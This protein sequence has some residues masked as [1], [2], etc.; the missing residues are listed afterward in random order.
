MTT[1]PRGKYKYDHSHPTD[2]RFLNERMAFRFWS[3]VRPVDSGCW[4]WQGFRTPRLGYGMFGFRNAMLVAHRVAYANCVGEIPRGI[5]VCHHC[6]NPRCVNPT[7]LFLGTNAD[8]MADM[9]R[10]GRRLRSHCKRGH[11]LVEGNV[12]LKK[13]RI[14]VF[15][16]CLICIRARDRE[17]S[18]R[19]RVK[20]DRPE[21]RAVPVAR[22]LPPQPRMES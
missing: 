20:C 17:Y 8:N 18:R 2:L 10:K 3:R 5:F 1:N 9:K 7:H 13:H 11:P 16:H 21:L 14:G 12:R 19:K 4:E 22:P 15:R 6:D